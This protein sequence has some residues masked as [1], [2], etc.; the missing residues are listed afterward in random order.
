[1]LDDLAA[2]FEAEYGP[3]DKKLAEQAMRQWPDHQEEQAAPWFSVPEVSSSWPAA[4]FKPGN[5][6]RPFEGG[7]AV[8]CI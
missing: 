6:S 7:A 5:S 2:E 3:A 8:S 1:L 4:T